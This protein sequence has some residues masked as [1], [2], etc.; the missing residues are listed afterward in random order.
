[1]PIDAAQHTR[2]TRF[3]A[4]RHNAWDR[5]VAL[6]PRSHHSKADAAL[7]VKARPYVRCGHD[8]A[9]RLMELPPA[10]REERS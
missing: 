8:V 10:R 3:C 6:A 2:D 5:G 7:M 1:M 4:P 9:A